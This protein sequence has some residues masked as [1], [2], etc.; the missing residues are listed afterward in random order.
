SWSIADSLLLA[1]TRKSPG[2]WV[3]AHRFPG[4]SDVSGI[5]NKEGTVD[6]EENRANFSATQGAGGLHI[7]WNRLEGRRV[8]PDDIQ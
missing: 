3:G 7:G 6:I 4:R 5:G 8:S 2:K 1:E